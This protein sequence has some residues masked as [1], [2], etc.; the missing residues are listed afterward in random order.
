[1]RVGGKLGQQCNAA[2]AAAAGAFTSRKPA[3]CGEVHEQYGSA[4]LSPCQ[5]VRVWATNMRKGKEEQGM[6]AYMSE[7]E[8]ER[9]TA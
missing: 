1:M 4:Y 8:T 3:A 2:A 9:D 6:L 7:N 5:R